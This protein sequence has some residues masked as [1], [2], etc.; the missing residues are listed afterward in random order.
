LSCSVRIEF[1]HGNTNAETAHK[2][3]ALRGSQQLNDF[4]CGDACPG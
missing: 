3:P 4:L 2:L 1:R